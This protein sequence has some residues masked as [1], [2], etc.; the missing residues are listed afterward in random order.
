[1]MERKMP[2]YT[3]TEKYFPELASG[4]LELQKGLVR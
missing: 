2:D 3:F 4:I 1:M